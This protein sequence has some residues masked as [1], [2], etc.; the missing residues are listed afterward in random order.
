MVSG[1][2]ARNAS[3]T[4]QDREFEAIPFRLEGFFPHIFSI[5]ITS[6]IPA[7]QRIMTPFHTMVIFR[8]SPLPD[9][10]STTRHASPRATRSERR[11]RLDLSSD[12]PASVDSGYANLSRVT[13][14]AEHRKEERQH[15]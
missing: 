5:P 1:L 9:A 11:T 7:P 14:D 2:E 6:I 10:I 3:I 13:P 15:D 12:S 8:R 4:G